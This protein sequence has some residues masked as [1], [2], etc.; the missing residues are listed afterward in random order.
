MYI[1]LGWSMVLTNFFVAIYYNFLIGLAIRYLWPCFFADLPWVECGEEFES[2]I[3][4]SV[5]CKTSQMKYLNRTHCKNNTYF[6]KDPDEQKYIEFETAVDHTSPA[7][8]YYNVQVVGLRGHSTWDTVGSVQ[9][10]LVGTLAISWFL[11]F[12][13]TSL[14]TKSM[15]KAALVT[16]FIPYIILTIF[17]FRGV[18]EDGLSTEFPSIWQQF[19]DF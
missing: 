18:K 17:L 2:G 10:D 11:T 9:A 7:E 13:L 3:K 6:S 15:G 5:G 16:G 14:G 8:D 4:P 12:V 1:G 19:N